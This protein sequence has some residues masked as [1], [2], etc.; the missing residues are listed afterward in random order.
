MSLTLYFYK[1]KK[2]NKPDFN[3]KEWF[4]V[5]RG[6]SCIDLADALGSKTDFNSGCYQLNENAFRYMLGHVLSKKPSEFD[7]DAYTEY[8]ELKTAMRHR[9]INWGKYDLYVLRS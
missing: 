5:R 4:T 3:K 9:K 6:Y 2:G 7:Y 1:V 8:T